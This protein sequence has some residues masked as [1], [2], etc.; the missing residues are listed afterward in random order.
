[1]R[2][3]K[4][5]AAER[6]R[7]VIGL[8]ESA[9][10]RSLERSADL[11]YYYGE[12]LAKLGRLEDAR[13]ALLAG[14]RLQPRDKRFAV[15]LGGIEFLRKR[16]GDSASWL[17]LA[18]KI[19]PDDA[20]VNDFC[21]S[22]FY[23]LGN[24]DAAL[25]YWN[26]VGKPRIETMIS[27]PAPKVDPVLLD[28]TFAF[29]RG[30]TLRLSELQATQDRLRALE[31]F[32]S[33]GLTLSARGDQDFDVRFHAVERR[34]W[35]DSKLEAALS[36]FRGVFY[37]TLTPE[38]YNIGDSATNVLSLLRWDAQKRRAAVSLSGPLRKDPRWRYQV[39]AD[40]RGENW[41]IRKSFTGPAPTLASLNLRRESVVANITSIHRV[42]WNWSTGV[43]L[44]HRDLR[45]VNSGSAL[46]PGLLLKGY[47]LKHTARLQF[48]LLDAP[49]K[50]LTVVASASTEIGRIWA[51][52]GGNFFKPQAGIAT[53]WFPRAQGDDLEMQHR[54]RVGDIVGTIPFDELYMLGLE[55]DNDLMMRAHI[56]TRDGRKGSA[57]LGRRYFVSNWEMDKNVYGNGLISVKLGPFVDT[58]NIAGQSS[59]GSQRWLWDTGVQAKVSV[60]GVKFAL[61]YGRDVRAGKGA[62]YARATR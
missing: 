44:S 11:D 39:G 9:P 46:A 7:D 23:L 57:P 24:L 25:K 21:G 47:Q 38:Y 13:K 5:F 52:A 29:A 14:Y 30:S 26:R 48:R 54:V 49:E 41:V 37:Q 15:E 56:G 61:S 6:W 16:Y 3:E 18:S 42:R 12:S 19:S 8:L 53:H 51:P 60:L 40:L 59:L 10:N 1:M 31:I 32:P 35:G 2:A 27:E 33:Y 45:D 34:G 20:Y 36:T 55:R 43:E 50:R 28:R 17:L 58:G 4:L 22:V 62:F